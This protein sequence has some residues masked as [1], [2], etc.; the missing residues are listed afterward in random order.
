MRYTAHTLD[1]SVIFHSQDETWMRQGVFHHMTKAKRPHIGYVYDNW[2]PAYLV[3]Q[4]RHT[5]VFYR[6]GNFD[7]VADWWKGRHTSNVRR[8]KKGPPPCIGWWN[9]STRK[10]PDAWRW[11]DG[12]KWSFPAY[13]E[14]SLEIVGKYAGQQAALSPI[15]W[16]DYWPESAA[17]KVT[18]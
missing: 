4:L 3:P 10:A 5:L 8:W 7:E 1:G 18:L 16:N 11:W 9:A 13:P 6:F 2:H 12:E 14:T 15:L 17:C